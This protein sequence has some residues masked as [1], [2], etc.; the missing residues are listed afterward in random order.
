MNEEKNG[1]LH[2]L[3][4]LLNLLPAVLVVAVIITSLPLTA[5]VLSEI[6][7]RLADTIG[8]AAEDLAGGDTVLA[9]EIPEEE[10]A[11][12]NY[13][14]GVYTGSARGYGGDVKVQVT[15]ENGQI[16]SV[17]ILDS[18]KET[19]NF[20]KKALGVIDR[21]LLKQTWEVDTVSGATYSSNGILGAIQNALTG[22]TVVTE[23]PKVTTPA[24]TSA[25]AY[26]EPE[27][28]KDGTYTGSAQGFGGSIKMQVTIKDGK[29][30]S[31]SVISASGE[32]SSYFAKAKSVI[33]KMLSKQ[34]P[35]V[36]TVSG[37]TYSS[38]GIINAVKKA[39]SQAAINGSAEDVTDE[40]ENSGDDNT[41]IVVPDLMPEEDYEDGVY[42]GTAEGFGGDI[43]MRVT[44]SGGKI[45]NVEVV[46][47]EDETP[48]FFSNASKLIPNIVSTQSAEVD[49][50]SGA[51]YSSN[52]IIDA[53]KDALSQ[54]KS[55]S[56]DDA[57]TDEPSTDEPSTDDA[58][59]DDPSADDPSTDGPSGNEPS[60]DT[61][62]TY[63][64]GVYTQTST[65]EP[66][67]DEQFD[68][69]DLIISVTL[70]GDQIT[71]LTF[72]D[73]NTFD[74]DAT[75]QKRSERALNGYKTYT[76]LADQLKSGIAPE[77]VDVVS[78][79]TCSCRAIADAV[80]SVLAEAAIPEEESEDKSDTDEPQTD[81][82][83]YADGT[84]EGSG[85]G[86]EDGEI[87]MAVTIE[88]GQITDISVV[89]QEDQSGKYWRNAQTIIDSMLS[90]QTS[91]VDV[92]SGATYSS[93]GIREA[94]AE[95]LE[96]AKAAK[97]AQDAAAEDGAQSDE[98]DTGADTPDEGTLTAAQAAEAAEP[99]ESSVAAESA[100]ATPE[101]SETT[102]SEA[103]T[104]A[105]EQENTEKTE[106]SEQIT[107]Q[108][109][110]ASYPEE[111]REEA[112][113]RKT[114]EK[115]AADAAE[116]QAGE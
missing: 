56:S 48:S 90:A 75:N 24:K 54:A 29:I 95:A 63:Y 11:V 22:E 107:A 18:S 72:A 74:D 97:A 88:N 111:A 86:Y 30:T 40:E 82:A 85:I 16:V 15:V 17:E 115:S 77:D 66:D 23:E 52:G 67:E 20:F 50:V 25:I 34:S 1:F 28:Y 10:Q 94:V 110:Q 39:L 55:A 98:A 80:R 62:Q 92:I 84:Y 101:A 44:I 58:S 70:S 19:A 9:G 7:E 68:A 65:V 112:E 79:A 114:E 3:R 87:V 73:E 36:D 5:P 33:S 116:E 59:G 89:S 108:Q 14:D 13:T 83:E 93:N 26:E 47:A 41:E 106:A 49:T 35:N 8:Q 100:A 51:T 42:E 60:E 81:T 96:K 64:D 2:S 43:T 32:T 103:V 31:I 109:A 21:V 61:K 102:E 71:D 104:E 78:T 76:G 113:D 12:G 69:Y 57:S 99:S 37:A 45:V 53:V 6:P 38:R 46:S 105:T 4:P 27:G 91:Q